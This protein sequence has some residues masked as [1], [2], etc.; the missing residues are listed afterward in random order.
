MMT[1]VGRARNTEDMMT[2]LITGRRGWPF[3]AQ[4][5]AFPQAVASRGPSSGVFI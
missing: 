2:E 1:R 3:F 4:L 5:V